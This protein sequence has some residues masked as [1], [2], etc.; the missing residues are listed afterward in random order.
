M[1]IDQRIGIDN[2]NGLIGASAVQGVKQSMRASIAPP[3]ACFAETPTRLMV[4]LHYRLVVDRDQISIV[5]FVQHHA[6][7]TMDSIVSISVPD[8]VSHYS[9]LV[10][11][12]LHSGRPGAF[13]N[14]P[15]RA[16]VFKRTVTA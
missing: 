3:S 7:S 1:H 13:E 9:R 10:L 8:L 15:G 2:G 4:H 12:R 5:P 16:D 6:R 14:L 11:L